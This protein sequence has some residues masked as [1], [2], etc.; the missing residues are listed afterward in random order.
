MSTAADLDRFLDQRPVDLLAFGE[1][2]HGEPAFVRARDELF[3]RLVARGFRSIAVE[4][5]RVAGLAVDDYVHGR[6]GEAPTGRE[7]NL[8]EWMR[9]YNESRPE[10]ERLSFHGFDAPLE[11]M[12]AASPGPY[13]RV[14]RD[15]LPEHRR[16]AGTEDL[17][18]LVG[19]DTRWSDPRAQLDAARSVG[20][21]ADAVALRT[22]ADDLLTA[23]YVHAPDAHAADWHRARVNGIA[24]LGLLRYHAAAADPAPRYHAAAAD[25]APG[26]AADPAP[27]AVGSAP[28]A[29]RT[30][31]MLAVRDALMA[32]NILDLRSQETGRILVA[33]HNRHLQRNPS[34]WH[35]AGMDL[36]WPSAGAIVSAVLKDRY[37]VIVGSLG[38]SAALGLGPPADGS[39]EGALCSRAG[40]GPLFTQAPQGT[41]RTDVTPE[42]QYF[43]LDAEIQADAIWHVDLFPPAAAAL[44]DRIQELPGVE[45]QQSGPE[46]GVPDIA[47]DDW[48]F[49]NGKPGKHPFATIVSH[50]IPGFD[51]RSELDR[52]GVYRLNLDLGRDEFRRLFGYGPEEFKAR[53]DAIDFARFDE[54]VPHPVYGTQSW[55]SIVNPGPRSAEHVD[56][57]LKHAHTRNHGHSRKGA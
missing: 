2:T 35:L 23:L 26:A 36:E 30:S 53:R 27:G 21:T 3:K 15:H 34:R 47:W 29:A 52:S 11:M 14:L 51:D 43:P 42:Q 31:R 48:F 24:A 9:G 37:A 44:A 54:F 40:H 5:D 56:R 33:A 1:P 28:G 39:F 6:G 7:K 46:L 19:D 25:P 17:D 49:F 12:S 41:T 10:G 4:F 22:L 13:L 50:D 16:P 55:A 45:S 38:S 32:R 57:L 18:R 20:R 8:A